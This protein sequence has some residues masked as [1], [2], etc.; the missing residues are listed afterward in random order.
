[1]V[2]WRSKPLLCEAGDVSKR[3]HPPVD[4]RDHSKRVGAWLRRVFGELPAATVP[5]ILWC[6]EGSGVPCLYCISM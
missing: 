2:D 4:A 1:M 3:V 6:A 5:T